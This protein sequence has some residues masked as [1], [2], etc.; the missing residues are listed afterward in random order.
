MRSFVS[1]SVLR[2]LVLVHP[3]LFAS[4]NDTE[5]MQEPSQGMATPVSSPDSLLNWGTLQEY[6]PVWSWAMPPGRED[7]QGP[8]HVLGI[9]QQ[10]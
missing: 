6:G 3:L 9:P 8:D 10:E 4:C 5:G 7:Q 1:Q 2:A